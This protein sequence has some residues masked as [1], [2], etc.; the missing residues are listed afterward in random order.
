ML[1]ACV[2]DFG[3]GWVKHLP[4]AEFSYNNSYHASIKAAPY[5]ALYGRK[6]R[7][8]VCW[9]EVG[10]AQLTSPELIQG[11]TKKIV[12][13]KQRMQAAQDRQKSYYDRKRNPME[14]EVGDR[15]MLKVSPWKGVIR[16]SKRGKQNPRYVRPF[17]VL[18]KVG[19]VAYRLELPQELSRVHHTFH[20]SNLK[21]CYTDEPLV[22]LLEGIHVDDKLQFVEEPVEIMEREIKRLKRS[23]IPLVKV[24]WNSRRGPEFTWE[25]EDSE[26]PAKVNKAREGLHPELPGRGDR[27]VDFLEGKVGVY[28]KF[29]EFANFRIPI[30]QFLFDILGHYQI[31]LSQLSV[32]GAAKVFPTVVDWHISIP[33][34]GM[35]GEGTYSV[36]DMAL[37]NTR[38]TPI[39]RQPELLLCLLGLSRR[40]FLGDDVYPTFLYD[41][42]QGGCLYLYLKLLVKVRRYAN[43]LR[44]IAKMDLFNLISAPNP[45]AVNTRT[46][47]R[48]AHEVPLLT[49][50]ASRVIDMKDVVATS[51]SSRIPS[52][53][54]KSPLDFSNEDTSLMIT[55]RGETENPVSAETSQEDPPAE[56]TTTAE[57]VLEVNLEKEVVAIGPLVNKRRRKR[58][59][60]TM[61]A[62][63]SPKVL[64]TDHASVRPELMTHGGK[65]LATMGVGAD[66]PSHTLVQQSVSDQ[67]PLSYAR[68]QPTPEPDIAHMLTDRIFPSVPNAS[69]LRERPS[70]GIQ[71]LRSLPHLHPLLDRQADAVDHMVP[72][73][74]F[75]E[76]RHLPN[77]E[78]LNQYKVNLAQQVAMGS[79][80]RLRFVQEV[81]LLKKAKEKGLRNQTR[82]LET[83][84]EAKVDMKKAA[85]ANSAELTKE[86]ESLRAKFSDLQVNSNQ[87]SQQVST[88]QAQ[89]TGEEQIKAA[90]EEF[91]KREDDKVERRCAEMDARLDALSI[92]FDEELYPHMLTAIASRRWVIGYGLRLAVMKCA[93]STELR[94]VFAN[95]VSAGI[96]KGVSKGLKH[97]V[98]H[99]KA[100]LDLEAIEAYDP[101]ADAKYVAALHA[102]KD[103]KYL[104]INHLKKLKDAPID[105]IMASLHLESD[106][107]EYT[108]QWIR[109]LRPSSSQLKIPVYP[110]VRDPRDPWAFKEEML[111]EDAIMANVSRAEKKKK[112]RV[113]RRTH[114]IGSAHHPR[115]DGIPVSVPTVA[116]Q[117]LAILLTDAATQTETTEDEA[118]P[119][120]IRSKSLTTM[121][122][123]DW[124]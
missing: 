108:L 47:P 6:C 78:F 79:Q 12:L 58:D 85:D 117:G 56:N 69:L 96:A 121:Y 99:G 54:E 120:L 52:A 20:V 88:L 61:E 29:F 28:T 49:T 43:C 112:C 7:S 45:A 62:N 87:L 90:F 35:P 4:L 24:R 116:P 119:R 37:L 1:R 57:V 36:E 65:S 124:P 114:G 82:N 123:L 44:L 41:D 26:L 31:H 40:Y 102:L 83:L 53:M 74:Y 97:G 55:N 33:K 18:V 14:Y 10:E 84:L 80:L 98:E 76:L 15:V 2:I 19:K 77:E 66:T 60:S 9:A 13:I 67:D 11:T 113:V 59:K 100:Q 93:E 38:R 32:I 34:D 92:D 63:T 103:V 22:M 115:T 48:A 70:Q 42:G 50:I 91:K 17:K 104:L 105:L 51:T 27:I 106:V 107:G 39:Q 122:N 5:E 109:E 23:L 110:E 30:S 25:R 72:P 64:R 71:I 16:F 86:L 3:K 68:P 81:R 21:K 95:V 89:V 118:S 101:K 8:P 46:R 111:L 73:G 75:S 94:Q